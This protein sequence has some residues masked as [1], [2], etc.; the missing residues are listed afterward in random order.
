MPGAFVAA[1]RA[2]ARGCW[3]LLIA[4]GHQATSSRREASRGPCDKHD[5]A[6]WRVT[7]ERRICRN[8]ARVYGSPMFDVALA[9]HNLQAPW[10]TNPDSEVGSP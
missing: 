4:V 6:R 7:V 8:Q 3:A 5:W 9:R 2:P 1:L 10:L